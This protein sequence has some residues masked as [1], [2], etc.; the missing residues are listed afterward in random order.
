[1]NVTVEGNVNERVWRAC[2][3]PWCESLTS[4]ASNETAVFMRYGFFFFFLKNKR[5]YGG[6]GGFV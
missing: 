2:G 3:T 1:M 6:G 5:I 4:K